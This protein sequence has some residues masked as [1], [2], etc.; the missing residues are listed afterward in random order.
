[1]V[2]T[3]DSLNELQKFAIKAAKELRYPIEVKEKL[4]KAKNEHEVTRI[5]SMERNKEFN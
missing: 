4:M 5:M 3:N 2:H 1:M